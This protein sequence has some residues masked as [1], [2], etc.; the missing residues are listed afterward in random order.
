LVAIE[1]RVLFVVCDA[2]FAGDCLLWEDAL[3]I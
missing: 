2:R 3:I 1:N